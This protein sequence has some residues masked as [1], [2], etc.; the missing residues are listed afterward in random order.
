MTFLE[1]TDPEHWARRARVEHSRDVR[2]SSVE[3]PDDEQR[4]AE[5]ARIL[6][7]SGALP[8]EDG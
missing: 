5:V 6:R 4:M 1:R 8:D 7:E 2:T 3:I